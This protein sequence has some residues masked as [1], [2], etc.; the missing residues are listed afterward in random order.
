MKNRLV[1][2]ILLA[3]TALTLNACSEAEQG[4]GA[5]AAEMAESTNADAAMAE[6][7]SESAAD[8]AAPAAAEIPV[9]MPKLAYA[10]DYL[11]ALPGEDLRKL[12][13]Q[14][15]SSCEQQGPQT[16]QIAGMTTSG[17]IDENM[18]GQLDLL[19]A[20][21]HARAFGALLEDEAESAGAEQRTAN[22][23]TEEVSRQ[24]VDTEARLA[25][26]IELRD[27]LREVL[28]TRRGTVEELI[29]AE[30]GVAAVNE[31]IDQTRAW[32]AE[33]QGRVAMSRM[34]VRYESVGPVGGSFLAPVEA[35]AG[36]VGAILGW[37]LAA[38]IIAGAVV[39][40]ILAAV[41]G[42]RRLTRKS[43][44]A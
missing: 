25:S 40:P 15:A 31:E 4:N 5:G 16:C 10:Y 14:H 34:T 39:L 30:R 7:A 27:R 41:F 21:A 35:A 44:V 36:S 11:F 6:S 37:L 17:E 43:E 42:I 19:V 24:L 2:S 8:S 33:T 13:R 29:E 3:S 12:Q 28:R 1:F 20:T 38:M 26:R 18:T 9:S 32:L 23:A 22:I